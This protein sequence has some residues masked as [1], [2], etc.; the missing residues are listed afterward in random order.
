MV[1]FT[2]LGKENNQLKTFKQSVGGER[3]GAYEVNVGFNGGE[4]V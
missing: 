4:I 3:E 1:G 2:D